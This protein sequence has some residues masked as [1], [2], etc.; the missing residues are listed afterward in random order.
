[1]DREMMNR[2]TQILSQQL[3]PA[4]G[5]TEPVAVAYAAAKLKELIGE[6]PSHVDVQ[7]SRNII[8]NA[9]SVIVPHTG[10]LKGIEA[11]VA[12]GIIAGDASL[13]LDVLSRTGPEQYAE[14]AGYV[15]S[16]VIGVRPMAAG[17]LFDMILT[18][19]SDESKAVVRISGHHTNLTYLER[20]GEVL[21]DRREAGDEPGPESRAEAGDGPADDSGAKKPSEGMDWMNTQDILEYVRTVPLEE[22]E[23]LIARQLEYNGAIAEEG[24]RNDYG[25]NIGSVLLKAAGGNPPVR[26][27]AKAMAAAGSDARMGGCEMPVIIVCG[28]GNQGMTASLPIVE[29]AKEYGSSR[30]DLIRAV[31]L[32]DLMAVH[33]KKG[34][35][36]LSA[37]CGAVCAGCGA[38]AG[39]AYLLGGDNRLICH[40]FVNALAIVSGMICDGAKPSCAAKIAASVDAGILGYEMAVQGQEFYSGEGIITK[41]IEGNIRNIGRL[42]SLGMKQTDEEIMNI[43]FDC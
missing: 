5:C 28:S 13:E 32:S 15:Q 12:A 14:M 40:T 22:I 33:V 7:V 1:M 29:Y 19:E 35:G 42:G 8:K 39:I 10:G 38:G 3:I 37:F 23:P 26:T 24:L 30:G 25:A 17:A 16:G 20:D 43:M 9:K 4:M 34:I 41:G 6:V 21:L 36:T 2:Y 31:A 27:R 18:G 11:A